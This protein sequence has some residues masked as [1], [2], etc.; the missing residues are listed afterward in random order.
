MGRHY[1]RY[2]VLLAALSILF[3]T[4]E[5]RSQ[6]QFPYRFTL[7]S[8]SADTLSSP[9]ATSPL[10]RYRI[11]AWGTY[12][13]WEDTVNS[14]VDP[15]WIYSFPE[16]EWAKPEWRLFPEG[17]P[18]YVGDDRMY[19]SHGLR[20]NDKPLPMAPYDSLTHRYSIVIQGNGKPI[21]AALVDWNFK[22]FTRRDAHDNN[23]GRLYV[24]VEE[25]PLTE[26]EICSVDSSR[27]PVIRVSAKVMRDSIRYEDIADKLALSENGVPVRI[28]SVD[29]SERVVPVSVA[30]VFD[31]SGSMRE[32]FGTSTRIVETK[33]AGKK[34]ADKL[35]S[36]DEGAV[37]SFSDI[38]TVDQAWTNNTSLLRNA[39][40]RLQPQGYT[41]MNDAILRSISDIASRPASFRKA[42]VVLS[43][44]E[45]N[46][47]T[48]RDISTV[49]AR[50]KAAGVPVFAIG[51]LLDTEDSLRLLASATGGRYF[52]VRDAGA[53]DS[54]FASVGELVF[55]KG[56]CSMY[57]VSPNPT[58]NGSFRR[59]NASIDFPND[60]LVVKEDGYHAPLN[61]V[62]GVDGEGAVGSTRIASVSPNPSHGSFVVRY[63]LGS[64][65]H[66]TMTVLDV[67]G[68]V[69]ARLVDERRDAGEYE[70]TVEAV[71]LPSGRYFVR[72]VTTGET[73]L[74]P[75]QI[76]R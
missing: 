38:T 29:C 41:A 65:G 55:E 3:I 5:A 16:E 17:Y 47:S 59:V 39:I 8:R 64:A 73:F 46:R 12:S 43:D 1:V 40:D 15:M 45:D 69:V 32:T 24:L 6:R 10:H 30:L 68:A 28:D 20:I 51:L 66:L 33:A 49:I 70:Q 48:V 52:S 67:Q 36:I 37:Y 21:T 26:M 63:R 23:S 18:I 50:A 27:F 42:I 22:N 44:G 53:M 31:R 54:V 35:T 19:D 76:V 9:S 72:L 71:D 74:Y 56:C 14:S 61:G 4:S 75:M 2:G 60:T 25:L 34:F 57:Y 7:D 62:S 11:T 13:M 58:R